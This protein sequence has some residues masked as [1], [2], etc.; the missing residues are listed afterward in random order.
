MVSCLPSHRGPARE[1]GG[2]ISQPS[3]LT[4]IHHK[5]CNWRAVSHQMIPNPISSPSGVSARYSSSSV[6]PP[7]PGRQTTVPVPDPP[8][9]DGP[10]GS[11]F[12]RVVQVPASAVVSER[13]VSAGAGGVS[14][15]GPADGL[16]TKAATMRPDAMI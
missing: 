13:R 10:R 14:G 7:G 1:L 15:E 9:G 16:A 5:C 12:S 3:G 2:N 11:Y 4:L 8:V 6:K